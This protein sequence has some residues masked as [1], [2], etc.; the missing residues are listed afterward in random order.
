MTRRHSDSC[1]LLR[2]IT[3]TVTP[4]NG[5]QISTLSDHRLKLADKAAMSYD[6]RNKEHRTPERYRQTPPTANTQSPAA[7]SDVSSTAGNGG[8]TPFYSA[9]PSPRQKGPALSNYAYEEGNAGIATEEDIEAAMARL[10]LKYGDSSDVEHQDTSELL[11]DIGLDLVLSDPALNVEG[12]EPSTPAP[13]SALPETPNAQ[14]DTQEQ[15]VEGD[16]LDD[17]YAAL[18]SLRLESGPTEN[19]K[20]TL[21]LLSPLSYEH[22][23]SRAWVPKMYK[24]S[25]VERPQR[26][27]ATSIGIGAAIAQTPEKFKL[28]A[29]YNKP[30]L[31]TA[32]HVSKVHGNEWASRLYSLC[33]ESKN[34]LENKEVEVPSDW[35]Q[36][37]IYLTPG[38]I[39]AL[40][41]VVGAVEEGID[42][43]YS[44][45]ES[46]DSVFVTV[47][48]P[49]H[50]SH[51]CAP[52]GFCLINNVHIAIQYAAEKHNVTH[53]VILDFDLHHG[54]GSQDICWKLAGLEQEEDTA[55]PDQKPLSKIGYFSL[56]DIN[57]YPTETGYASAD[58]IKNASVC[59]MAHGMCVWNVHL[60]KFTDE[61]AFMGLYNAK[62]SVI[63]S[64]ARE[65]LAKARDEHYAAQ[66]PQTP[67]SRGSSR[68]SE[69][70]KPEPVPFKPLIFISAGFDASENEHVNMRRH[71][72]HVPTSFYQRFTDDSV[73]LA[74]EFSNNK[75]ISFLEGGYSDGAL[76]TGLYSHLLGFAGTELSAA[77]ASP[78]VTKKF[79]Q[80]CKLKWDAN[81]VYKSSRSSAAARSLLG[82]SDTEW[83]ARSITLGRLLWPLDVQHAARVASTAPK[84]PPY[85]GSP[86][87]PGSARVLRTRTPK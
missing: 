69:T 12:D 73:R 85:R 70:V 20:P 39:N 81:S 9:A 15:Q 40:E 46:F 30:D 42:S 77:R 56:H 25:I 5:K 48:P 3:K 7:A 31:R 72:V 32:A 22:V 14:L 2:S 47:R 8:G 82:A 27:M 64:K 67:K 75:I 11:A 19:C 53:A 37:D 57:S 1:L 79:E 23:F 13:K 44:P 36:G 52:S 63:F 76:S 61:A 29:S 84:T 49:G 54:D 58:N 38:T 78:E 62:Y 51:T 28:R 59:V 18:E 41:G 50:H 74:K 24:S 68:N 65:Y 83:L 33:A 6:S 16:S 55:Y 71:G 10:T 86:G 45:V 21:V 17:F 4:N 60:E 66:K 35:N 87:E 43:L 26:L 34:K 80:G